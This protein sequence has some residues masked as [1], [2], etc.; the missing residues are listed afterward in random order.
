MRSCASILTLEYSGE[1][2]AEKLGQKVE[3]VGSEGVTVF[4][5]GIGMRKSEARLTLLLDDNLFFLRLALPNQLEALS[6]VDL[7]MTDL[8]A[9]EDEHRVEVDPRFESRASS[10]SWEP[11]SFSLRAFLSPTFSM[12]GSVHMTSNIFR[13]CSVSPRLNA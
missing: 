12:L 11:C 4:A 7:V 8:S 6:A 3:A 1:A 5:S 9:E 13:R 10:P 2:S